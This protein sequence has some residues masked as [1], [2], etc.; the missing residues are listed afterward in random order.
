MY[1]AY[2]VRWDLLLGLDFCFPRRKRMISHFA[3]ER[4]SGLLTTGP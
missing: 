4:I 1:M 3:D 2:L